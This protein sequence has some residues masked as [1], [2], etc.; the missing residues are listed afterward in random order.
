[1]NRIRYKL[2]DRGIHCPPESV[3]VLVS[4]YKVADVRF[5]TDYD[6]QYFFKQYEDRELVMPLSLMMRVRNREHH[7][8]METRILAPNDEIRMGSQLVVCRVNAYGL[9]GTCE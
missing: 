3:N 5:N 1:V 2:E 4:V 7:L 6:D 8:D 9:L